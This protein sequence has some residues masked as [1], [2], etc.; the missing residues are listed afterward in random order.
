MYDENLKLKLSK[1]KIFFLCLGIFVSIICVCIWD[2]TTYFE[3]IALVF[4]F[5]YF[6]NIGDRVSMREA[7]VERILEIG[8]R[9]MEAEERIKETEKKIG[10]VQ[11]LLVRLW[12]VIDPHGWAAAGNEDEDEN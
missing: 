2:L 5:G 11:V 1:W 6:L 10:D 4:F 3:W 9:V 7:M 8:R 12:Q